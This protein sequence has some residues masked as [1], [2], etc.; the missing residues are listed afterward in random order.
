M[1]SL[2]M[3]RQLGL[4]AVC[5]V[6]SSASAGAADYYADCSR[7]DDFGDGKTL[8][9]AK[10]TIQAAVDLAQAG[11]KVLVAKG[12]Y[13]KG[14]KSRE[15]GESAS[16]V[17]ITKRLTLKAIS[18]NPADTVILGAADPAAP[19]GCG[20]AAVRGVL[21]WPLGCGTVIGVTIKDGR[22]LSTPSPGL[23]EKHRGDSLFRYMIRSGAGAMGATL[24]NCVVIG[25]KAAH[26]GGAVAWCKVYDSTLRDCWCGDYGNAAAA[27][28]LYNCQILNNSGASTVAFEI[29]AVNCLFRG[30]SARTGAVGGYFTPRPN[31]HIFVN[32]LIT[33]NQAEHAMVFGQ[34][35]E[36]MPMLINCTVLNN[37]ATKKGAIAGLGS[38]KLGTAGDLVVR[39]SIVRYNYNTQEPGVESNGLF[40]DISSVSNSCIAPDV[41]GKPYDKGGNV[42]ADPEFVN[43]EGKDYRLSAASPCIDAGADNVAIPDRVFKSLPKEVADLLSKDLLGNP[44]PQPGKNGTPARFDMGAYEFTAAGK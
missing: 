7:P 8:A 37:T 42:A 19:N 35:P 5:A 11:D 18:E 16:R 40:S 6:L 10:Q 33:E 3:F 1:I 20:A 36:N 27:T 4:A 22:T 32:C 25:C 14:G 44:R 15:E 38:S 24:R 26:C 31:Y 39:N 17:Y 23:L 21:C 41:T 34:G 13:D 2:A 30:N 12:I 43:R 28:H 9:T 29:L